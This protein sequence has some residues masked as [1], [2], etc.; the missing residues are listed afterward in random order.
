MGSY[1]WAS[2]AKQTGIT[3]EHTLSVSGGTDKVKAYGSF[4]YL[5]QKGVEKGQSF[6]RFTM[7]TSVE[8]KPLRY[9]LMGITMNA[10][11]GDQNYG[12]NFA[13]SVTGSGSYYSAM[14]GMIPWTVPYDENGD[15]VTTPFA[16]NNTLEN[17]IDELKYTTNKRRNFR[18]N[19]SAYAQLDFGKIWQPLDGLTYRIQF[20][21]ELQYYRLGI[22]YAK[23][24]INGKGNNVAQYN[25]YQNVAWVLDNLIYYNKTIAKDHHI[26]VTLLQSASKT[27]YESGFIKANV[28]TSDELWY[29]TSSLADPLSYSTG[30]TEDHWHLT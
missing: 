18:I 6:K 1:D 23:E 28:A 22:A 10:S 16:Y 8:I 30:L 26:G 15:V 5:N 25:P 3:S 7:N 14:R 20:G 17:P 21:P 29:N 27:H 12:Y 11:Y 4:G 24:S 9:F 2:K 13:A 19:G